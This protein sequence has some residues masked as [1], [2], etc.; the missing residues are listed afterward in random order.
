MRLAAFTRDDW[1]G[2][3]AWTPLFVGAAL[4]AVA[5]WFADRDAADRRKDTATDFWFSA[6]AGLLL[7]G[8]ESA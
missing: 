4:L 1:H 3:A 8:V 2:V 5:A 6:A 7:I